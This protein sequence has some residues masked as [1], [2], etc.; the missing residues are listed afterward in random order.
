MTIFLRSGLARSHGYGDVVDD[1]DGADRDVDADDVGD[2]GD[3]DG[4]EGDDVD[5]VGNV[6]DL[7][8]V[9][10]SNLAASRC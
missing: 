3:V 1:E 7:D 5:D 6:D 4:E 10:G 8:G 9:D 2:V